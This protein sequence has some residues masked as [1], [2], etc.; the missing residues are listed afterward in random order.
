MN[1]RYFVFAVILTIFLSF[2]PFAQILT[3][4][5]LIFS[6]FIHE[7]SHAIGAVLTGGRVESVI[8][9]VNGSGVT[10]TQGGLRFVIS[11]AG[12]IGT[13]L[14]GALLLMLSHKQSHVRAV[15]TG[16]TVFVLAATA[17]FVGHSNNVLVL[18]WIA[19]IAGLFAMSMRNSQTTESRRTPLLGIASGML[20]LL[21]G[22][23]LWTKS[24]FSW[25]AGLLI[26]SAL[27]AVARFA[28]INFAHFFLTFLAVQCSLNA[29]DAIKTLYFLSLRSS[30]GNDAASMASITGIPAWIWAIAWAILSLF[31]LVLSTAIYVRKSMKTP[32]TSPSLPF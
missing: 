5:F 26:A 8:V 12:Y 31:I 4:P 28:S 9:H 2:L 18:A 11:S 20:L 15:L 23:L 1:A 19:S 27:L 16:C 29:L 30:C 13:T 32:Q 14:F 17:I 24:L 3:Y 7:I 6:T 10:L 21:I 25:S 22:Y